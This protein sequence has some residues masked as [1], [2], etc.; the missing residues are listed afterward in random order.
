MAYKLSPL[1]E[2]R[3]RRVVQTRDPEDAILDFLYKVKDPVEFD[4]ILD[5]TQMDDSTAKRVVNRLV[6]KEYVKVV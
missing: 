1:G 2:N 5:E 3:A 6:L 4:E